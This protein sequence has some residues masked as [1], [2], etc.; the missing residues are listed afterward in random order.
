MEHGFAKLSKGL[1]ALAAILHALAAPVP[2]FM[3][4]VTIQTELLGGLAIRRALNHRT[5]HGSTPSNV[6]N[7][8]YG[9]LRNQFSEEQ[10]LQRA[11]KSH[12]KIIG[13]V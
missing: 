12:L 13:R 8:L 7:D 2:H 6:S 1:D 5:G 10:L 9:R 11:G 3:A 4:W